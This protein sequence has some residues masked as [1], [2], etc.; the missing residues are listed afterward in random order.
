M[1]MIRQTCPAC[2]RL[3]ELPEHAAGKTAKCPACE[4]QFVVPMPVGPATDGQ[5][6]GDQGFG[7]QDSGGQEMGDQDSGASGAGDPGFGSPIP[8]SMDA[9]GASPFSQPLGSTVDG[10]RQGPVSSKPN[11]YQPS[12]ETPPATTF[13]GKLPIGRRSV[14]EIVGVGFAIF[15]ERA[16]V[17][18]GTY[19]LVF[20]ISLFAA[21]APNLIG[22]IMDMIGNEALSAVISG[23]SQLFFNLLSSY[24][25][26]GY[27]GVVLAV[28]RDEPSPFSRL[29]P[30]MAIFGRFIGGV[31][32][33]MLAGGLVAG[34]VAA[35]GALAIAA[36]VEGG[37]AAGLIILAFLVL[38]PAMFLMYW[39]LWSWPFIVVD[40]K[41]GITGSIKASFAITM[42]NKMTSLL[43]III[44]ML[45]S[46]V[47]LL[48]CYIGLVVATPLW[49]MF[50]GAGYLMITG[51]SYV[52]PR[53]NRSNPQ[54]AP[55]PQSPQF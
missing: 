5:G 34:L 10:H 30:S 52:D 22:M 27:C 46:I 31:I 4:A 55:R 54:F 41:A 36:G 17:L 32:L 51:Q 1:S 9:P 39:L 2:N 45:L 53:T 20:L 48:A 12:V 33:L 3:L 15:K 16:G 23:L 18:I 35:V 6:F 7:D 24:F 40:G 44:V 25:T 21:F 26:F 43:L 28:A 49:I 13:V 50:L 29:C 38:L 47:G 11:P 14:E 19:I 8:G 42:E 37:V